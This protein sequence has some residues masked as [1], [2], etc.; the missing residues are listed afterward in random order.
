MNLKMEVKNCWGVIVTFFPD[1]DFE[2]NIAL[3]HQ[4]IQNLVIIDNSA[5][6]HVQKRLEAIAK[7]YNA[8]LIINDK[9]LGIAEALNQGVEHVQQTA[10]E[11]LFCFDQDSQIRSDY[12]EIMRRSAS[13]QTSRLFLLGCNYIN[14]RSNKPKIP[15]CS[16]SSDKFELVERKTV[17]TSGMLVPMPLINLIGAFRADYFIDS[18]DH[19]Y[20]LRARKHKYPV[21]MTREIGMSHLI[22]TN[23]ISPNWFMS[24]VPRHNTLRKYYMTRNALLTVQEYW[25]T[26][27]MWGVKQ[28][29]RIIAE[30]CSIILFEDNKRAMLSAMLKG[31][32]DAFKQRTG[33]L[34]NG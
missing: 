19:E 11:W 6:Q 14:V 24:L 27:K 13:S 8:T 15:L 3:I 5:E 18:V 20:C 9:N 33:A 22:G 10:A 2:N 34:D 25:R 7:S 32:R 28:L 17:I 12:F 16:K 21:L 26:E 1:T 31:A 23:E 4:Q 29:V 30:A